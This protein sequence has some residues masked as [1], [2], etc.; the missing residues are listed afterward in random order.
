MA[1]RK[2]RRGTTASGARQREGEGG[3]PAR[4]ALD[5]APPPCSSPNFY[6]L[7]CAL[8]GIGPRQLARLRRGLGRW[9]GAS[10]S[11]HF[12]LILGCHPERADVCAVSA[13]TLADT[14]LQGLRHRMQLGL[15][16]FPLISRRPHHIVTGSTRH[17]LPP[18]CHP[19]RYCRWQ[20]LSARRSHCANRR[21]A[22]F[23]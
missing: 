20:T 1:A 3:P 18:V 6:E 13:S 5:P 17:G 23:E 12:L 11:L 10:F 7:T 14:R 21:R 22:I 15:S 8:P 16:S 9:R 2:A 19:P 4:L